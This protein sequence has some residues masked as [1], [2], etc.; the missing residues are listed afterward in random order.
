MPTSSN[1]FGSQHALEEHS[2]EGLALLISEPA[3]FIRYTLY[4]LF[5]ILAVG[6]GWSFFGHADVLVQV[7]GKLG[8]DSDERRVFAPIDGQL[9]NLYIAEGTPVNAGDVM[10]RINALGAVEAIIRA[11]SA[12]LKLL[13]A[14]EEYRLYP[15]N[16][17]VL[18]KQI[19]TLEFRVAGEERVQARY[20]AEGV[21][22]LGEEQRLKLQKAQS[23]LEKARLEQAQALADYQKHQRLFASPGGGGISKQTVDE[24][25]IAYE[26]KRNAYALAETEL[27]EFEVDMN[28]ELLKKNED[29]QKKSENLMAFRNELEESKVR[30]AG[31]KPKAEANLRL[32]R[33]TAEGATRVSFEDIDEDDFL[34]LRAPVA[35]VI[36]TIVNTQIGEMVQSKEP[37]VSIAPAD[38]RQVLHVEIPEHE[39]AFLREGMPVKL[40]FKAFAFQRYGFIKGVL[41]YISPSTVTVGTGDTK[42]IVYKGRVSLEQ[43]QFRIGDQ[44]YPLRYGMTA[45]AEIVV[46]QRRLIDLAL[47]PFRQVAG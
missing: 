29:I 30:L 9:V 42:V 4:L 26:Q 5:V 20:L 18:K 39:R 13:E 35:G 37:F 41:E 38:A 44:T 36:T 45:T 27:A 34:R 16:E 40:K 12:K 33:L 23:K 19:A 10:A 3:A 2:A 28:K 8:P 1:P 15:Y 11:E 17:Q 31:L 14:E 24:K 7:S 32:A 25:R 21:E 6:L 22:K 43:N 47:D 46:R